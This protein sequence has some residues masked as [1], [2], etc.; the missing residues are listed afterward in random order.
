L[1]SGGSD[2]A[3]RIWDLDS[4]QEVQ[5]LTGHTGSIATLDCH[6]DGRLLVSGSFDT[7]ARVWR[8][9]KA[10]AGVGHARG[11]EQ[12]GRPARR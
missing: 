7:T 4:G 3:I 2:N 11:A 1:A 6:A 9:D 8:L 10:L 5:R 12:A